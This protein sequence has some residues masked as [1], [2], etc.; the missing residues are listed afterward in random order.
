V[1]VGARKGFTLLEVMLAMSVL[2]V[3]MVAICATTLRVH[4]LRREN[5][6]RSVAE[7]AVRMIAERVQSVSR[8]ARSDPAGWAQDVVAALNPGGQIG[9]KFQVAELTPLDGAPTVGSISVIT[10]ESTSDATLGV[11]LG[12]PRDLDGDGIVGNPDVTH[13]AR[14]LPVIVRASWKGVSGKQEVVHP[15]YVLGY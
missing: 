8:L 6:D 12:M 3:A 4:A 9:N 14:L 2:V 13:T 5:R 7:N 15:F 11:E 1:R 10:N